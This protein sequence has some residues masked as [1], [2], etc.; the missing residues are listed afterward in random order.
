MAGMWT[1]SWYLTVMAGGG[2]LLFEESAFL[3]KLS[4]DAHPKMP[5]P[6][7]PKYH[8]LRTF[9]FVSALTIGSWYNLISLDLPSLP[10]CYHCFY[11]SLIPLF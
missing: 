5:E 6:K 9:D 8:I 10:L 4:F 11:A 3:W 2:G 1:W 7:H